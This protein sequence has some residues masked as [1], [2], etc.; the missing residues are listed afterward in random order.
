MNR[1]IRNRFLDE[2]DTGKHR[3]RQCKWKC[4][5][6]CNFEKVQYCIG[7]ALLKSQK[8]LMDEGFAFGGANAYRANRLSSVKDIFADIEREY[9]EAQK[10]RCG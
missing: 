3:P 10:A 5:R 1:A 8:G 7:R 6:P 2:V 4:L 9:A